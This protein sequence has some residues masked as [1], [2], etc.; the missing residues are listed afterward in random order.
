LPAIQHLEHYFT[1]MVFYTL[2]LPCLLLALHDD[3]RV[4]R[5]INGPEDAN[6][7]TPEGLD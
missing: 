2:F 5:R 4:L 7:G 3:D 1:T 6:R